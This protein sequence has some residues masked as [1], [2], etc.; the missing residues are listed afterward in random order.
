[1][2]LLKTKSIYYDDVN[3]IAQPTDITNRDIPNE[4]LRIFVSPMSAIVGEDLTISAIN[5]GYSV[6]LHRFNKE[7]DG[8]NQIDMYDNMIYTWNTNFKWHLKNEI[9]TKN[10][11]FSIGFNGDYTIL[12]KHLRQRGVCNNICMDIANGYMCDAVEKSI[13]YINRFNIKNFMIGNIH[14][15]DMIPFYSRII[16]KTNVEKLFVRCGISSGTACATAPVTGYNR[17]QIT[18]LNEIVDVMTELKIR[19]N[20][21]EKIVIVADGGIKNSGCALKAFGAGA[22]CVMM[23]GYW[24][25]AE[26]AQTNIDGEHHFYGGASTRQLNKIG[27]TGKHSEGKDLEIDESKLVPFSELDNQLWGGIKSGVSYSGYNSLS[28]FIGN[29]VFELK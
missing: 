12:L 4:K 8:L 15:R 26:E 7:N 13:D 9:F 18:E 22:D 24:R 23:G 10:L 6:I 3:L 16:D 11:W 29:G 14:S 21:A 1:M 19:D 25:F 27:K 20:R 5:A 17:G 28:E 2:K